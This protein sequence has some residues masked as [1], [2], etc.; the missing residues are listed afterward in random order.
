MILN[1]IL[2]LLLVAAVLAG[3]YWS[4][5]GA[6]SRACAAEALAAREAGIRETTQR[7]LDV[8]QRL[9]DQQLEDAARIVELEGQLAARSVERQVVYRDRVREVEVPVCRVL[10]VQVEAI[11]EVIR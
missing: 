5:H 2:P 10:P 11:N 4:G 1:R 6:A 9:F 8:I 7:R 3:A